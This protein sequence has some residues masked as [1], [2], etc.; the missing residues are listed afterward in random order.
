[1]QIFSFFA[2]RASLMPFARTVRK[3][4]VQ[5]IFCRSI[6]FGPLH[7]IFFIA[8]SE[9]DDLERTQIHFQSSAARATHSCMVQRPYREVDEASDTSRAEAE[10]RRFGIG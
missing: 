5:Q 3:P 8:D 4:N 1:M 6:F 7:E 2:V 10:E 9:S